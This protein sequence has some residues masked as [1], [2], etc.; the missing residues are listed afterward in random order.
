MSGASDAPRQ[1][2]LRVLHVGKFYPP[3]RGGMEKVLQVLAESE[4]GR[5]DSHVL[6]ANDGPATV[7]DVVNGVTVTRV[8]AMTRVGAVAVCPAFP[9]WMSKLRADVMV[10]HEPNPVALV[11]HAL[12]RPGAKVVFWVHAEVVRPAWRYNLFYR[13]FLRRLLNQADRIIV[14]SPPVKEHA[15]ALRPFLD[16]CVVIPYAIEPDQHALPATTVTEADAWR[17]GTSV[18]PLVLFVGRLVG[19]KGVDILLRALVDVNARAVIVGD[20]PLRGDLEQLARSLGLNDRVR[21]VG[22]ASAGELASWYSA[23]DLFVLPSVTRAEAFGI[24]QLEAM[25]CR[26]PVISTDLPS[27]VPWVNQHG[28]TGLVVPPGDVAALA[29]AIRTLAVNP[30]LR[31]TMGEHGRARVERDFSIGRLAEQTTALYHEVASPRVAS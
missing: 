23:C 10:I 19:Y 7:H 20:G 6:V 18:E 5:V 9:Y 11:S 16:K 24:V 2:Q 22:K 26:K 27:G 13:P 30:E 8:G 14:A 1:R 15:V 28:V 12:V 25:A 17:A 31:R 3:A 29:S 21:L 4:R